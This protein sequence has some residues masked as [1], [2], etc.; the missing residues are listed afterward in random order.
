MLYYEYKGKKILLNLV[1][2]VQTWVFILFIDKKKLLPSMFVV[3]F[4][5]FKI[6]KN[7]FIILY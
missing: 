1:N 7:K 4:Q 5:S 3:D 2:E 6:K